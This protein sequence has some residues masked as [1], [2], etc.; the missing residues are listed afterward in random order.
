MAKKIA[1]NLLLTSPKS[2]TGSFVYIKNILEAI[3]AIDRENQYILIGSFVCLNFFKK[4]Y[5]GLQNVS[6]QAVDIRKDLIF[7]SLRAMSKLAA[8]FR[9]DFSAKEKII[10]YEVQK[11]ID[12]EG[13]EI[14][15]CPSSAI[16]P[17]GLKSIK[18]VTTVLD[19]QHEYLPK[20]F[21]SNYLKRR[22]NDCRNVVD[23]SDKIIAISNYTKQSLVEKY[24]A[25]LDKIET[26]YLAPQASQKMMP[27]RLSLNLPDEYI[28]YPAAIWPHKNHKVIIGAVALLKSKF[29][30]LH[31]VF[32]GSI[33]NGK[34]KEELDALTIS[35][36][37]KDR[38]HFLGFVS[39]EYMP[40]IY[41]RAKLF[42]YPSSFEGFGIPL[43][44]AFNYGV[45]VIAAENTSIGEVVGTAGILVE[46]G[47]VG[48]FADAIEKVL[49]DPDLGQDLI[50]R[51]YE[52]AKD[53][54]WTKAANKTLELFNS[55]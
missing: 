1:V 51:G 40:L 22:E 39:D 47:N 11:V 43:V 42:V 49:S 7:N 48:A 9:H 32:S 55:L 46:T 38:V 23:Y 52:R 36:N 31:L 16:F 45:P 50:R 41:E 2:V 20:N 5:S 37:L 53:F 30:N 14:F 4:K 27:S 17:I 29:P 44:E 25:N 35:C 13:I 19:L 3:F 6:Y 10:K 15:F 34:L 54:S 26:I 33:K 28:F 21:S 18:I 12:D 24:N 8:K